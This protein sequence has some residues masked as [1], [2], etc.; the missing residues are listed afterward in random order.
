RAYSTGLGHGSEFVVRL[1]AVITLS[2]CD[3]PEPAALPLPT[4][5][6]RVLVVD[7]NVDVAEVLSMQLG[8][9]GHDSEHLHTVQAAVDQAKTLL[10]DVVLLD[11]GLPGMDGYQ[12]AQSLRK[13]PA[14]GEVVL[15][16]VS[17][18]GRTEDVDR[19]RSAG[20]DC[21]LVKPVATETLQRAIA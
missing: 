16:A 20:F 2:A 7:D 17:G 1:P 11:L 19:S 21:H 8:N 3:N 14:L 12:V 10:P 9:L 18:Y 6:R 5:L 4:P 15:I 13:I